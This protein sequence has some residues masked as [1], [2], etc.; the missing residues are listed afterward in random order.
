[1]ILKISE[2]YEGLFNPP[3][4]VDTVI[5]TGGRFS[6]KSFAVGLA[7][8]IHSKIN[9]HRI[10]YTRYTLT[11]ADDS[12]IPEFNE[13]I[14]LLNW[15][16]DFKVTQGRIELNK[17]RGKI[18]FKGIKT[19]SGN[20]T[21]SLKSLKDFSMFILEE[22]EEMP[23]YDDWNKIKLSIRANDVQ[24]LS[25]LVL[26]PTS[27]E[28]WIYKKFFEET[29]V[30]E[31]FNGVNENV[32]Y[33][34]TSYL[35]CPREFIP[36]NHYN[37]FNSK[38]VLHNHYLSLSQ[39]E[40]ESCDKKILSAYKYYKHIVLGGW[41]DKSEGVIYDNWEI[42]S[43]NYDLPYIFGLDF[44]SNDPDA[45]TRVAIDEKNK[46]IY[47]K[48]EYHKNNTS[49]DTL[50]RILI[51]RCGFDKLI[52]ADCA[53]RRMINDL[54]DIGL[55]IIGC[56]KGADSVLHGIKTIQGYR[57]I[58]DKESINIHVALNNYVWKDKKS[59]VP[60]HDY[61]DLMDSF[62]YA[63]MYLLSNNVGIIW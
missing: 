32:L 2:K 11:S 34:H 38:R 41:L 50:T 9:N 45:L 56:K 62:R 27:K 20:Q 58:V 24:N 61:S 37:E 55:N 53:E 33:I 21:A 19:S 26:N 36:E 10:L 40:K 35:D 54:S 17:G 28:H 39:E 43:Y 47:L 3:K 48:Q 23:S 44:G 30:K 7:S 22:A 52:I 25:I 5:V 57:I 1:M 51:D 60:N 6:Q 46:I 15:D 63:T 14:S 59:G 16:N 31:G 29:G 4:G 42:G 8:C 18:V 49:F 12:I 13:K